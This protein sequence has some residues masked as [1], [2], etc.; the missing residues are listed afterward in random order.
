VEVPGKWIAL[1]CFTPA[2]RNRLHGMTLHHYAVLRP[3]PAG[4]E[5][6]DAKGDLVRL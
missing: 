6:L 2:E 3:F 5:G 1:D 4:E